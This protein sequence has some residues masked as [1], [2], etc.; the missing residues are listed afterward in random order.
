MRIARFIKEIAPYCGAQQE[1]NLLRLLVLLLQRMG[2]PVLLHGTFEG[3][4]LRMVSAAHS[5]QLEP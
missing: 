5:F 2:A 4:G 3:G 1:P